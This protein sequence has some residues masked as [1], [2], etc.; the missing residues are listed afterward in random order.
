MG[1]LFISRF[2]YIFAYMTNKE[3]LAELKDGD[4]ITAIHPKNGDKLIACFHGYNENE[5]SYGETF[6]NVE[7]KFFI[8][9][10]G[11][12]V[13]DTPF[14]CHNSSTVLRK[15]TLCETFR[16][17][18]ELRINGYTYNRKTRQICKKPV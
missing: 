12:F 17:I 5:Y 9:F 11:G 3:F 14:L 7:T 15:A 4:F 10:V 13:M 2:F 8:G 16:L 1:Y 18:D 6:Y